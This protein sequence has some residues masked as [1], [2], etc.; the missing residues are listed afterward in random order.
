MDLH[1]KM[2]ELENEAGP[3]SV[4][5]N[6]LFVGSTSELQKLIKGK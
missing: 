5:N 6:A 4:T 2:K 3:T 1:L